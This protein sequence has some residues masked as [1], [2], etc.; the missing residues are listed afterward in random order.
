MRGVLSVIC[1]EGG[2]RGKRTN[3]V[4]FPQPPI[5]IISQISEIS[6]K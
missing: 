6:E 5:E 3:S 1:R 2:W 4:G